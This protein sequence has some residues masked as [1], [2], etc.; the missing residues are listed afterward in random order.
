MALIAKSTNKPR[1][2]VPEGTHI[3]R[4]YSLVDLGTQETEW[5]GVTKWIHK[6]RF[7]FEL[8]L[9]TRE[10]D[11][12]QKP[13]VISNEYS[14][15]FGDK[16]N[17]TKIV[18]GM[19]GR[20]LTEKETQEG[21]DLKTLVGKSCMVNV[22]HKETSKGVYANIASVVPVPKGMVSP[23]QFNK[24]VIFE[25]DS[26]DVELFDKF[27]QFLKDKINSAKERNTSQVAEDEIN[28]EDVSF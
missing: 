6:V 14:L 4:L 1:E 27:P 23:E 11:G 8:P 21:I 19:L 18:E 16:A 12:V 25:I 20:K 13:L 5:Q 15:S 24:T 2:V 17:L 10:F 3:A 7:T 9:E 22:I 26:F 28:P